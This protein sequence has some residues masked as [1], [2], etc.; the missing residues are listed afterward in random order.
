ME[1]TVNMH[2]ELKII[3][4][5]DD[6]IS[7]DAMINFGAVRFEPSAEPGK[8]ELTWNFHSREEAIAVL[9]NVARRL[10]NNEK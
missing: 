3:V 10:K 2:G 8:T 7:T 1:V 4:N 5:T 6:K 9:N